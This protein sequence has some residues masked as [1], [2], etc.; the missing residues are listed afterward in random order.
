[1]LGRG[2]SVLPWPA[3]E[4]EVAAGALVRIR[5]R[6]RRLFQEFGLVY[7]SGRVPRPVR[8]LADFCRSLPFV[9]R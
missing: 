1:M 5:V 9:E 7:G 8:V 2:M 6:R 3:I 4:Q